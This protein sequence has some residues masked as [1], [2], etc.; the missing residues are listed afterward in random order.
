M[1]TASCMILAR[2]DTGRLGSTLS[3]ALSSGLFHELFILLDSRAKRD[4][5]QLIQSYMLA[6]PG[7]IRVH[8]YRWQ[9]PADFA[10]ARNYAIS[11][12]RGKYGFWLDADEVIVE[13]QGIRDLLADP[14]GRAFFMIVRSPLPDGRMFDMNQPR[15]FPLAP[16]AEF[17]CG[18]FERLDWALDRVGI[19]GVHTG[20]VT[21]YHTGYLSR[22]GNARK[23]S[24]NISAAHTWLTANIERGVQRYHLK[25]QQSRM[26]KRRQG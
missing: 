20:L 23:L 19:E 11:Q 10:A 12:M 7:L 25:E 8:G 4:V 3:S 1:E 6:Y 14:R 24:R 2:D 21:I 13:A 9:E 18:V 26:V 5:R 17:E 15:L 16:G 22:R